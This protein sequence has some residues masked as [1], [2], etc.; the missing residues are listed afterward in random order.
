M[1]SQVGKRCIVGLHEQPAQPQDAAPAAAPAAA[2]TSV[3]LA[4]GTEDDNTVL[5]LITGVKSKPLPG[6]TNLAMIFAACLADP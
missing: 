1:R 4:T 5:C 2:A 3:E 6:L